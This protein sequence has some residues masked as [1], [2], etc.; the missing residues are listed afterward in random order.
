MQCS[1]SEDHSSAVKLAQ[2]D[3]NIT[4]ATPSNY[5]DNASIDSLGSPVMASSYV[6]KSNMVI[7]SITPHIMDSATPAQ[8]SDAHPI[9]PTHAPKLGS[10][11]QGSLI[12]DWLVVSPV[13][14]SRTFRSGASGASEDSA[15]SLYIHAP[16]PMESTPSLHKE[17][18]NL[19]VESVAGS[20]QLSI[21]PVTTQS[22]SAKPGLSVSGGNENVSADPEPMEFSSSTRVATERPTSARNVPS[23]PSIHAVSS[24]T[25]KLASESFG[26]NIRSVQKES[27]ELPETLYPVA[28]T[29]PSISNAPMAAPIEP[30]GSPWLQAT[31]R[32]NMAGRHF[33]RR[34]SQQNS[35]SPCSHLASSATH[36]PFMRVNSLFKH[37]SRRLSS[38]SCSSQGA[39]TRSQ[40]S[41]AC[42]AQHSTAVRNQSLSA[43]V[44]CTMH[45]CIH[46]LRRAASVAMVST[47]LALGVIMLL[48]LSSVVFGP[49][50]DLEVLRSAAAEASVGVLRA[51]HV[52]AHSMEAL[53]HVVSAAEVATDSMHDALHKQ[54]S[55]LPT[56]WQEASDSVLMSLRSLKGVF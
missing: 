9:E 33:F 51:P 7:S 34:M 55:K 37:A 45:A 28:T 47:S 38:S 53:M 3:A 18:K 14:P 23:I 2:S 20:S 41:A 21:A 44:S 16:V 1:D 17:Q 11:A 43:A 48:L 39:D 15:D 19:P 30:V 22:A 13:E 25:G 27:S 26:S 35:G 31:S 29:S 5:A 50:Q 46:V 24:A 56:H 54:H 12:S 36:E 4:L 10:S 8:V 42:R 49:A 52:S 6:P 32:F 40:L